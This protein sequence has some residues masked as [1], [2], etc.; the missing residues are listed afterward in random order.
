MRG[1]SGNRRST[2][3][4]GVN[5]GST[6]S[7]GSNRGLGR[8]R[9]KT[10]LSEEEILNIDATN[11]WKSSDWAPKNIPF[12]GKPGPCAAAA[13]SADDDPQKFFSFL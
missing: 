3:G 5:R 1:S 12:T 8:S 9:K 10:A 7:R 2:R 6:R 13:Q 4:T 11:G